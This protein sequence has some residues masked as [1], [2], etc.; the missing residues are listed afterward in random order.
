MTAAVDAPLADSLAEARRTADI[1]GC[2]AWED[3]QNTAALLA[4]NPHGL[5]G[6][7]V[8]AAAGLVR[9]LWVKQF[10][11]LLPDDPP[12]SRLPVT[13][14]GDR[15]LGGLDLA[16]TLTAGRPVAEKGVLAAANDGVLIAAMAERMPMATAAHAAAALDNGFV[17]VERDGFSHRDEARFVMLLLDESIDGDEGP[18]SLLLERLAFCLDLHA[19]SMRAAGPFPYSAAQIKGA[20]HRFSQIAVPDDLLH[21]INEAALFVGAHSIRV[22]QFCIGAA[23][24]AAALAGRMEATDADVELACRLVLGPHAAAPNAADA[25][26]PLRSDAMQEEPAPSAEDPARSDRSGSEHEHSA[27]DAPDEIMPDEM[28]IEALAGAALANP[29]SRLQKS[30]I[31]A[32]RNAAAGKSG[33]V[34]KGRQKGR[35]IAPRKGDPRRD[36]RL[37]ILATLRAAAPWQK[38]RAVGN[39]PSQEKAQIRIRTEDFHVKCFKQQS[40]STVIFVVDASGS[41][42]MNRMAEAKGA[43]ERLLAD[44]YARRDNVALIAFRGNSAE[45]LLPPTRALVRAR[46]QLAQLPGG[47]GTPLASGI[48]AA[49]VL[50]S[51]EK[52]RGRT[53]YIVFLSDGRGNIARSGEA[54]R[55]AAEED[56]M[57]AARRLGGSGCA[58]LFFDT[59]PRPGRGAQEL[60]EAMGAQYQPLPFVDGGVVSTAV[61]RS[62]AQGEGRVQ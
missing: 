22:L 29:L 35:P 50:A 2:A 57:A 14:S 33:E 25:E 4:V 6:A 61:R 44:C 47:G 48:D 28:M 20:R 1:A 30:K 49:F 12:V 19:V 24:S 38:L 10:I 13:T 62:L 27:S 40:E 56:A 21:A 3:A 37:D 16:A 15:L 5:N 58:V 59:S 17:Q 42:A 8:R 11:A 46:R 7:A 18:S 43:I 52:S 39:S 54:G 41:S 34:S 53:P 36:G 45:L 51:A 9:D 23:R 60:G 32:R 55:K 31:A 26:Q